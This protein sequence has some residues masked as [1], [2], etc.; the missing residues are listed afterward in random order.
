M[1]K[2]S[3]T[4]HTLSS[5]PLARSLCDCQG[6]AQKVAHY[7]FPKTKRF[8]KMNSNSEIINQIFLKFF[9]YTTITL[10][11]KKLSYNKYQY[12]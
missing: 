2:K 10:T 7:R 4:L 12:I 1:S 8:K 5:L 9:S 3:N 6:N 11:K